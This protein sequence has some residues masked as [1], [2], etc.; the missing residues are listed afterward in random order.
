[1]A[2]CSGMANS[3]G[4]VR[5]NQAL[6][7][8]CKE[9]HWGGEIH[10]ASRERRGPKRVFM[11]FSTGEKGKKH[12]RATGWPQKKRVKGIPRFSKDRTRFFRTR[13]S[14]G[15]GV[16]QGGLEEQESGGSSRKKQPT[17]NEEVKNEG[18]WNGRK[19]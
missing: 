18:K 6:C 11:H 16:H 8:N 7:R 5:E 9:D 2:Q 19:E 12:R 1:M 17:K 15:E 14:W 3:V 4:L 13:G 10:K